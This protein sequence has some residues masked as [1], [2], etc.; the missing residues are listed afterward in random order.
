MINIFRIKNI[1]NFYLWMMFLPSLKMKRECLKR[2]TDMEKMTNCCRLS[3][4]YYYNKNCFS[5]SKSGL[6]LCFPNSFQLVFLEND[7]LSQTV[8]FC[9]QKDEE[10]Q[11]LF[12]SG[13]N[14]STCWTKSCIPHVWPA[15]SSAH[16]PSRSSESATGR[17]LLTKSESIRCLLSAS[18]INFAIPGTYFSQ[19]PTLTLSS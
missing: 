7:P 4:Y 6:Q 15:I 5:F 10:T 12:D 19:S 16:C 13:L 2:N 9:E 3:D 8:Y 18:C 1:K 14:N 11:V 17:F